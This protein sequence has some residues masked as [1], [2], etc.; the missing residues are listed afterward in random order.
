MQVSTFANYV[1]SI[2]SLVEVEVY[3]RTWVQEVYIAVHPFDC[4]VVGVFIGGLVSSS[5]NREAAIRHFMV[6]AELLIRLYGQ[7]RYQFGTQV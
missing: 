6:Y 3:S 2:S 7:Q 4:K 1:E 5:H